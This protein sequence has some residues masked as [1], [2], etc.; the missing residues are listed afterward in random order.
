MSPHVNNQGIFL[1]VAQAI[2]SNKTQYPASEQLSNIPQSHAVFP[3]T[4]Q[5]KQWAEHD[6]CIL[7]YVS[8]QRAGEGFFIG[9]RNRYFSQS[10]KR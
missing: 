8:A 7:R 4:R 9:F 2:G 6:M 3:S 10:V 5:P 1:D